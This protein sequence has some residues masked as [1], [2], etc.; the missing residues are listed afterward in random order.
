M[1]LEIAGKGANVVISQ[2]HYFLENHGLGEILYMY[3]RTSVRANS[4]FFSSEK[5]VYLHADNCTGQN[6]NNTMIQYLL[7][8]T[9][10]GRHTHTH[11]H[12]GDPLLPCCWPYKG[13]P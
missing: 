4:F 3:T 1:R 11:T 8:R 7:L 12:A 13:L 6:K 2:L 10:T 5:E 9:M